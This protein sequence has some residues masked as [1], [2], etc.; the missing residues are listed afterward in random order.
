MNEPISINMIDLT[1]NGDDLADMLPA[2]S[3]TRRKI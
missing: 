3:R 2:T 1:D